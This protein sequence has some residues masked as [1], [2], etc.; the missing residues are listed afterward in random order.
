M[1]IITLC[2]SDAILL[3]MQYSVIQMYPSISHSQI[4]YNISYPHKGEKINLDNHPTQ[5]ILRR[6]GR[7][8][9][10]HFSYFVIVT[11][12]HYQ[13]EDDF[14]KMIEDAPC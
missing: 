7:I 13:M 5:R 10:T 11:D 3:M 1:T 6:L 4:I 9:W 8:A 2:I 14:R 12:Y